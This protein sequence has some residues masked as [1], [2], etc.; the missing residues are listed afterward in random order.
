M[1]GANVFSQLSVPILHYRF[2]YSY[3]TEVMATYLK[4][5]ARVVARPHMHYRHQQNKLAVRQSYSLWR[6]SF[7]A[8]PSSSESTSE[9]ETESTETIVPGQLYQKEYSPKVEAIVSDI[10]ELNLLEVS[11][12]CDLLTEKFN[13]PEVAFGVGGGGGGGDAGAGAAEEVKE[14]QTEFAVKLKSFDAKAKIKL[15]KEVRQIGG[16]GLKE[17]KE[18]VESAPVILKKDLSKEDAEAMQEALKALGAETELE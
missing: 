15:I 3:R 2:D 14:E 16:F 13:I 5:I 4:S 17:A 12:L 9:N 1:I 10:A 7:C 11:E 18:I 6:R 8:T